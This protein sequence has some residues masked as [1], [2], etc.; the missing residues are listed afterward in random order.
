MH[1]MHD[2]RLYVVIVANVMLFGS[3]VERRTVKKHLAVVK[4]KAHGTQCWND[5]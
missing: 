1:R 3:E 4:R 2:L 5:S